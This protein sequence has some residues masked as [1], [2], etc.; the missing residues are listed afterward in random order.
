MLAHFEYGHLYKFLVS[1]G[2]LLVVLGI[3]LPWFLPTKN[4][5]LLVP[6][7]DVVTLTPTA[8]RV[9]QR[10]QERAEFLLQAWPWISLPSIG[11]G[12]ALTLHGLKKWKERQ[13]IADTR[14]EHERDLAAAQV[15]ATASEVE[16]KVDAEVALEEGPDLAPA[17]AADAPVTERTAAF[18]SKVVEVEA[19]LVSLLTEAVSDSFDVR[20]HVKAQDKNRISVLDAVLESHNARSEDIVVEVR[21]LRGPTHVADYFL[22]TASLTELYT[23]ATGRSAKPLLILVIGASRRPSDLAQH[24][25]Q[26]QRRLREARALIA[27]DVEAITIWEA[28]L[29]EMTPADLRQKLGRRLLRLPQPT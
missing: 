1:A 12:V 11:I 13:R 10:E 17:H 7:A 6:A 3:A 26:V 4:D 8:Q 15:Q 5:L 25:G 2:I 18:R 9:L 22:R 24:E 29:E 27:R 20:P 19:R 21:Y 23:A 14:E 28:D 16:R